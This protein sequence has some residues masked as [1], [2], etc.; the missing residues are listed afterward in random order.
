M[1]HIV[2]GACLRFSAKC[3]SITPDAPLEP[4]RHV[5]DCPARYED[6]SVFPGVN[7]PVDLTHFPIGTRH[8]EFVTMVEAD[9]IRRG[10]TTVPRHAEQDIIVILK[11]AALLPVTILWMSNCGRDYAPWNGKHINVLGIEDG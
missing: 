7:G 11:D 4:G 10:W 9:L 3:C 6:F 2:G 5:L 8:E 1:V